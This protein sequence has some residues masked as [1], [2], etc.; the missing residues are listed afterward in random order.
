MR[1]RTYTLR[2]ECPLFWVDARCG[3]INDSWIASAD[4]PDG[5]SLG[6]GS[7]AIAAISMALE[8]FEGVVEELLSGVPDHL[9]AAY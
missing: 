4:T 2:L 5:P 9:A 6:Y 8:P 1:G 7:S 3:R